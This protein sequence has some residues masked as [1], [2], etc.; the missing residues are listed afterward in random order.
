MPLLY[1]FGLCVLQHNEKPVVSKTANGSYGGRQTTD[2]TV[3]QNPVLLSGPFFLYVK[4]Y[5]FPI[6]G[7]RKEV[8]VKKLQSLYV[9]ADI[10]ELID[11]CARA[12]SEY[13]NRGSQGLDVGD[14]QNTS[15]SF[16][17]LMFAFP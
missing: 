2:T 9:Y 12:L 13:G 16:F 4:T 17:F 7:K 11:Y 1:C 10:N 5:S 14:L 15:H 8:F 6:K 3:G